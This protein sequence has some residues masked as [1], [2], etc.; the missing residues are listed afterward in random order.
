M[1]GLGKVIRF[2][3]VALFALIPI[4]TRPWQGGDADVLWSLYIL[5]LSFPAGL[6]PAYLAGLAQV[7]TE[8]AAYSHSSWYAVSVWLVP[9]VACC[10]AGYAQWFVLAPYAVR[11]LRAI[12]S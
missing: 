8:G 6:V 10:G 3:Y 4:W 11:R 2:A 12:A 5:V 7:A 9:T 1:T